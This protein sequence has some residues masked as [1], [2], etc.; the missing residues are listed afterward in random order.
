MGAAEFTVSLRVFHPTSS[1]ETVSASLGLV[2]EFSWSVG[3]PRATP[4]GR[5]LEGI[6]KDTY[7]CFTML[8]KQQGNFLEALRGLFKALEL[9]GSYLRAT[10]E[11]G[12][13]AELFIGVFSNTTV[14]FTLGSSDMSV[15][16]D[17]ALDLS[18]EVY[19]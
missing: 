8:P 19:C 13:R 9:H 3:Q 6:Y 17:L 1:A 16:Q 15:L 5:R 12:G 2:P 18:I 4:K 7:C 14:G 10:R 11:Q